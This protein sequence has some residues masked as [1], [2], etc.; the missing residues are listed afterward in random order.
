MSRLPLKPNL[1]SYR[2]SKENLRQET[3][4]HNTMALEVADY[5]NRKIYDNPD[6]TQQ[7]IFASIASELGFTTAEVRSAISKGGYHGITFYEIGDNERQALGMYLD[8]LKKRPP[9]W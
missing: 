4:N 7:Y 6:I 5:V 1:R 2:G 9:I 3:T 8:G